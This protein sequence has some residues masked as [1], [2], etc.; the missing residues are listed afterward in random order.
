MYASWIHEI[1]VETKGVWKHNTAGLHVAKGR[2]DVSSKSADWLLDP[3]VLDSPRTINCPKTV[4]D[5]GTDGAMR[6]WRMRSLILVSDYRSWIRPSVK[7]KLTIHWHASAAFRIHEFHIFLWSVDRKVMID[8]TCYL[9]ATN[10]RILHQETPII[11]T[12]FKS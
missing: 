12:V 11:C 3:I 2:T 4:L 8:Q 5:F 6:R 1:H 7:R 9:P 10:N